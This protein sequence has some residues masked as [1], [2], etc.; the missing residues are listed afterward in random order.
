M[1]AHMIT[2]SDALSG[3]QRKGVNHFDLGRFP[4][5]LDPGHLSFAPDRCR[6]CVVPKSAEM[7]RGG[8][9]TKPRCVI[10]L[11]ENLR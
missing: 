3:I 9:V 8:G 2:P 11:V 1:L 6:H 10:G 4:A 5:L 7:A